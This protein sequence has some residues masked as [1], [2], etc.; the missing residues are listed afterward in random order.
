MMH[1]TSSRAGFEA[2]MVTPYV[3]TTGKCLELYYFLWTDPVVEP[4]DN[5]QTR[6]E[7]FQQS[8]EQ[9]DPER[10]VIY[11]TSDTASDWRRLFVKLSPGIYRVGVAGRRNSLG[12]NCGS[13]VDDIAILD[14]DIFG[15]IVPSWQ[16]C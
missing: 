11:S 2:V 1:S 15:S 7:V 6:I 3:N 12:A 16:P 5:I 10:T 4:L 8:E 9:Q 13:F 14:C